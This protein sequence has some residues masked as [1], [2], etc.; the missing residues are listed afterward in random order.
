MVVCTFTPEVYSL[1]A[2]V[3]VPNHLLR[4]FFDRIREKQ[5]QLQISTGSK[6]EGQSASPENGTNS[7]GNDKASKWKRLSVRRQEL[8]PSL[9]SRQ[10]HLRDSRMLAEDTRAKWLKQSSLLQG[11]TGAW[12]MRS[13]LQDNKMAI[14][15]ALAF[16]AVALICLLLLFKLR[17]QQVNYW[18]TGKERRPSCQRGS[19]SI[20]KPSCSISL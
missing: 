4:K 10:S 13:L 19:S 17:S 15:C 9:D 8:L 14:I 11:D 5:L 6:A 12:E 20:G 3:A 2:S 18:R 7:A 16:A 1:T